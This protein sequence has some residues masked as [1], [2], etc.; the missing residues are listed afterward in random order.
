MPPVAAQPPDAPAGPRSPFV[1]SF[2]VVSAD[3]PPAGDLLEAMILDLE[4]LY[5]RIDV[6]G[7][8]TGTAADFSPPEG[9]FLVGFDGE[10]P[11]CCGGVKRLSERLGEIKRMYVVPDAR[12][13]GVARA[14]LEALER[15]A[16]QIGCD[17]V[18]LDTGPRQPHARVLYESAGYR[19]I[20]DYNGNPFADFWG[21][22]ALGTSVLPSAASSVPAAGTS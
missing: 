7:A 6:P 15:E 22:K 3:R 9:S 1:I 16:V 11:V 19:S 10:R 4:P 14:L 17:H 18:R 12:G 13:R 20:P 21:E 5:G 8:P 2:R